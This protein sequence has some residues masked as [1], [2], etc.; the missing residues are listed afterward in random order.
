M[1]LARARSSLSTI[2]IRPLVLIFSSH[3]ALG[4]VGGAAQAA[5]LARSDIDGALAPTV[6]Y[7]RHP[8]LGPPGGAT[9]PLATF[10]GVLE[11]LEA[12]GAFKD[13][14]A[15]I[16]GYFA[17]ADQIVAAARAVDRVRVANSSAW[18]VVDPIMGDDGGRYVSERVAGALM[19]QLAPRADLL[20]PNAWELG[21]L[22][23]ARVEGPSQAIAAA[24][25]LGCATLVSSLSLGAQI[26][27]VWTDGREAWLATHH[28][29]P[30]DP[31][32]A[33]DHLTVAFVAAIVAGATPEAALDRAVTAVATRVVGA[34]VEVKLERLL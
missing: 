6:L 10:E 18:I 21:S 9:V 31:K 5:E 26:G 11:G 13:A 28:R 25:T 16:T 33:G 2:G 1:C 30:L 12:A 24:Q 34:S 4:G 19:G 23:G 32:G 17:S 29:A 7:A 8:G 14:R 22:T 27:V 15:L 3:V 20:T